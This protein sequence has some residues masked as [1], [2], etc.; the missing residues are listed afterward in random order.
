MAPL[1]APG[2]DG[3]SPIFYQK[4]WHIVGPDVTAAILSCLRDGSLLKKINHTNICLIPKVQS[5]ES[6]KDI[7]L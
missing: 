5:P 1:K 7:G 4:Y 2:P 3:M 6:V